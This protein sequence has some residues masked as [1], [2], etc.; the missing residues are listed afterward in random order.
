M[1]NNP[2]Q[3][4]LQEGGGVFKLIGKLPTDNKNL[5][6]SYR[7]TGGL[8]NRQQLIN[9]INTVLNKN[10]ITKKLATNE[11][12]ISKRVSNIIT[13]KVDRDCQDKNATQRN[14]ANKLQ[15]EFLAYLKGLDTDG[16]PL[17]RQELKQEGT[18]QQQQQQSMRM[19]SD[20][21]WSTGTTTGTTTTNSSGIA[22]AANQQ[23]EEARLNFIR[24]QQLAR[25]AEQKLMKIERGVAQKE[26][27]EAKLETLHETFEMAHG[28]LQS[29]LGE[30]SG[31]K[32]SAELINHLKQFGKMI[33]DIAGELDDTTAE[34]VNVPRSEITS[35]ADTARHVVNMAKAG[36][37]TETLVET[38]QPVVNKLA[39]GAN[40]V[41][42]AEEKTKSE[43]EKLKATQQKL[44]QRNAELEIAAQKAKEEQEKAEATAKAANE[45]A[46]TADTQAA[47][48]RTA[49]EASNAKAAELE[50]RLAAL[51]LKHKAELEYIQ[52]TLDGLSYIPAELEEAYDKVEQAAN[53]AETQTHELLN[54]SNISQ[55]QNNS[56][57]L[58]SQQES[59][60]LEAFS[61]LAGMAK[62]R[63]Q[64]GK[65]ANNA[66]AKLSTAA[67]KAADTAAE[68]AN[69]HLEINNTKAELNEET[70]PSSENN[71]NPV[72]QYVVAVNIGNSAGTNQ[73][74]GN[75]SGFNLVNPA[76]GQEEEEQS[77]NKA[78]PTITIT[79]ASNNQQ[80]AQN[81]S[82][83]PTITFNTHI[84]G[85][86]NAVQLGQETA[87]KPENKTVNSS[88]R[89]VVK[90][91]NNKA[92]N[93][94]NMRVALVIPTSTPKTIEKLN[95]TIAATNTA[96]TEQEKVEQTSNESTS[97]VQA[98]M[99]VAL[100]APK[101]EEVSEKAKQKL[102]PESEQQEQ[103]EETIREPRQ[104][105]I[106]ALEPKNQ[107]KS[108]EEEDPSEK[109]QYLEILPAD[110][111][112]QPLPLEIAPGS[113]E[114]FEVDYA[115]NLATGGR[116]MTWSA[117]KR[118]FTPKKHHTKS[119]KSRLTLKVQPKKH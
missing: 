102:L 21:N 15:R 8:E 106:L 4:Q 81:E 100:V 30:L 107:D 65:N 89:V 64:A 72:N 49:R 3:Q 45:K 84:E 41:N 28:D 56:S 19:P 96:I 36:T 117:V 12:K 66:L 67:K 97:A 37:N 74:P 46:N 35:L 55:A 82:A 98:N 17:S 13:R 110:K 34:A 77:Q 32:M 60:L 52:T 80:K 79:E 59:T 86:K 116:K 22:Q 57:E 23:Y 85:E 92:K 53:I 25:E 62:S 26:E 111:G 42:A 14:L 115:E 101:S 114:Y 75:A 6:E 90:A 16:K 20:T 5:V 103:V 44:E 2:P 9:T 104:E 54:S 18:K 83:N 48:N 70:N 7:T 39:R 10:G 118:Y 24:T 29:I 95:N 31:G 108:E 88:N 47:A 105:V 63:N 87:Q 68:I 112:N 109:N 38:L 40:E 93:I 33:I 94:T 1:N 50:Q 99:N 91:T 27:Q 58:V 51:E 76:S 11:P 69:L 61:N 119:K 113:G 71:Q 43:L 73:K 78:I